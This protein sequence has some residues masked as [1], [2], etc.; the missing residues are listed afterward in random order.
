MPPRFPPLGP[1]IPRRRSGVWRGI[2]RG[3]LQLF[4][5]RVVGSFADVPKA[6]MIGAPHTSNLDG[7]ISLL[8]L[9]AMGLR[10]HTFIKDSAFIGPLGWLLRRLGALPIR[11]GVNGGM[12][13]Q[14]IAA[15]RDAEQLWLLLAPEGTRQAAAQW[16]LGFHHIA[17]GAGVP[18]VIAV[19][20]Y[21]ARRVT[22]LPAR[23]ASPDAPTDLDAWLDEMAEHALARHPACLSAPLAAAMARRAER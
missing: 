11:R 15:L 22:V 12:I 8:L 16:K 14:S 23:E 17:R 4:G 5:W 18:V 3:L 6:V 7:V 21:R 1:R 13:E 20:D 9:T 2:A 10:A 19:I